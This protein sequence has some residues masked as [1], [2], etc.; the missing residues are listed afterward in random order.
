MG[1]YTKCT[2]CG[3]E[4]EKATFYSNRIGEFTCNEEFNHMCLEC[5]SLEKDKAYKASYS[6]DGEEIFL[7][8]FSSIVEF[9]KTLDKAIFTQVVAPCKNINHLLN[10]MRIEPMDSNIEDMLKLVRKGY[11]DFTGAG[12]SSSI[13]KQEI[14]KEYFKCSEE[15]FYAIGGAA[16]KTNPIFGIKEDQVLDL[17]T[18]KKGPVKN[19]AYISPTNTNKVVEVVF[20][21][22]KLTERYIDK[23]NWNTIGEL[24]VGINRISI[25]IDDLEGLEKNIIGQIKKG[26]GLTVNSIK[27]HDFGGK[28]GN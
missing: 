2:K 19:I 11:R 5:I 17:A 1:N 20:T 12:T 15:V 26:Q 28:Y 7:F 23:F 21:K 18:F 3:K 22:L 10:N 25:A 16:E 27:I 13:S 8:F 9:F 6:V 24:V 14:I 4:I